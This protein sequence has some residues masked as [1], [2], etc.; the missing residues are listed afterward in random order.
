[1]HVSERA[2]LGYVFIFLVAVDW[3]LSSYL[4]QD[5]E[6]DRVPPFVITTVCNSLFLLCLFVHWGRR[7][8]DSTEAAAGCLFD[9]R[10]PAQALALR[11]PDSKGQSARLGV[12]QLVC[13]S[14]PFL[15]QLFRC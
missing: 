1:M 3:I 6:K 5:L 10:A 14:V 13:P 11:R 4:V 12:E 7:W 9:V 8:C 2:R 15:L